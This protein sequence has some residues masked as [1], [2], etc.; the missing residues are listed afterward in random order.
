MFIQ[1]DRFVL[2]VHAIDRGSPELTGSTEVDLRI[3]D[4]ND[5][6]P[7]FSQSNYSA[8]IQVRFDLLFKLSSAPK[9]TVHSVVE[10]SAHTSKK[11]GCPV[12]KSYF[13]ATKLNSSY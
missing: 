2:G 11:H 5:C 10:N 13:S 8:N 1:V 9:T 7:K 3:L 6:E 4:V 12:V